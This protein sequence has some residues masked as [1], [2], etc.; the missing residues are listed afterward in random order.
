MVIYGKGKNHIITF[1]TL[2][3]IRPADSASVNSTDGKVCQHRRPVVNYHRTAGVDSLLRAPHTGM[4]RFQQIPGTILIFHPETVFRLSCLCRSRE[5]KLCVCSIP[6]CRPFCRSFL[7]TAAA[8]RMDTGRDRPVVLL[9]KISV[10]AFIQSQSDQRILPV[11]Y[12]PA[13]FIRDPGSPV[14]QED[15]RRPVKVQDCCPCDRLRLNPPCNISCQIF[16]TSDAEALFRILM[17]RRQNKCS[18]Q[19]YIPL[20]PDPVTGKR[21]QTFFCSLNLLHCRFSFCCRDLSQQILHIDPGRRLFP[22]GQYPVPYIQVKTNPGSPEQF[23]PEC[24]GKL[25]DP[26]MR[27]IS[28]TGPVRMIRHKSFPIRRC[29]VHDKCSLL[30]RRS[31]QHI[32]HPEFP[33]V[34]AVFHICGQLRKSFRPVQQNLTFRMLSIQNLP[35]SR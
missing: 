31:S 6:V 30:L 5:R 16:Q 7:K 24:P 15:R 25:H 29:P 21:S 34:Y 2:I 33:A 9:H 10:V 17:I 23:I 32:C 12:A 13:L 3:Q 1:H 27:R 20:L 4:V 19:M 8:L 26:R 11:K 28:P 18:F 35:L 22:A 14:C